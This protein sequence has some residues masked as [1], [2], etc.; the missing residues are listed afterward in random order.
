[1][2]SRDTGNQAV[3]RL[4]ALLELKETLM[5]EPFTAAEVEEWRSGMSARLN[6]GQRPSAVEYI[7][8]WLATLDARD[9]E[10]ERLRTGIAEALADLHGERHLVDD[11]PALARPV[12]FE[13]GLV[14]P[15]PTERIRRTLTDALDRS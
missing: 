5:T 4:E 1:M 13:C 14:W 2:A 6:R 15:C 12:C 3:E 7:L 8:A 10:I 11:H 9:A